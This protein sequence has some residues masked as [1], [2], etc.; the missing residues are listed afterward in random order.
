MRCEREPFGMSQRA[1]EHGVVADR[2]AQPARPLELRPERIVG[3]PEMGGRNVALDR[4]GERRPREPGAQAPVSGVPARH[5]RHVRL[6]RRDRAAG[7]GQ[8]GLLEDAELG[9][10]GGRARRPEALGHDPTRIRIQP[11]PARN[12]HAVDPGEQLARAGV[13]RRRLAGRDHQLD[14]LERVARVVAA[15]VRDGG[16]T[17]DRGSGGQGQADL[18]SAE[19]A[20]RA[21]RRREPSALPRRRD[22]PRC[23]RGSRPAP[24]PAG[25]ASALPRGSGPSGSP[26]G[27]RRRSPSCGPA[28]A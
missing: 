19:P 3:A 4:V 16:A 23:R 25:P 20:A 21:A 24:L 17:Q 12:G 13:A 28:C 22:A 10:D 26:G 8:Q 15:L 5:Q 27:P 14:G 11:E 9:H 18:A 2:H 7:I 1:L 6:A